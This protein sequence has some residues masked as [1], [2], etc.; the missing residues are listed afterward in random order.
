MIDILVT[1]AVELL[2]KETLSKEI[3]VDGRRLHAKW[4]FDTKGE[5]SQSK[6]SEDDPDLV[7][8]VFFF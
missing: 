1:S 3:T 6:S 7:L 2:F 4:T 8:K 5:S